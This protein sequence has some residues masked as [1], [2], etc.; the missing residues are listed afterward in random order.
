MIVLLA[1]QLGPYRISVLNNL[2]EALNGE[3]MVV[4]TRADPAPDRQ[5]TLA[6]HEVKFQTTTLPGHRLNVGSGIFEL[7]RHVGST[8]AKFRPEAIVLNGWDMHASWTALSWA[9]RRG[10]PII[11]WVASTQAAGK[12][13]GL[14]SNAARRFFLEHCSAAVVPGVAAEA[15]VHKFIPSLPCY[16]V[17][18]A[19]DEPEL[20]TMSAPPKNGAALFIGQLSR[21]KGVDLILDAAEDIL[22]I[23]PRLII[24]GNGPLRDEVV[25]LAGRLPGLEYAGFVEGTDKARLFQRS[26]A[27]LAPSRKDPWLMVAA[28]A[29]VARRPIVLGPGVGAIP[30]LQPIAGDAVRLMPAATSEDLVNAARQVRNQVVPSSL[31]E[32]FRPS[33]QA[34]AMAAA[35]RST[36]SRQPLR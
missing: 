12:H 3:L 31:S 36:I 13:R 6:W 5:W 14:I 18:N 24:A 25:A 7:S 35:F 8:L 27:V 1:R 21:R 19:I 16:R 20:R 15:F 33:E 11:A 10:V 26:S 34:I 23:F 28:E 29:L 4:H 22:N 17:S 32:A 2:S 9:R 30:D